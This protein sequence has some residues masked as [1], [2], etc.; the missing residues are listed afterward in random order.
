M[1]KLR[2]GGFQ[3]AEIS[4]DSWAT[5][6]K[7]AE[8]Q[9]QAERQGVRTVSFHCCHHAPAERA[10]V[11]KVGYVEYHK[12][13]YET[14][15]A[16]ANESLTVVEHVPGGPFHKISSEAVERLSALVELSHEYG[17]RIATE[18]MPGNFA[19]P[20]EMES[21]LDRVPGLY[22]TFDAAHAG[23]SSVDPLSFARLFDERLINVHVYD[24]HPRIRLGDWLPIGLGRMDW[25]SILGALHRAGYSGPLTIELTGQMLR[26][27][28]SVCD[29]VLEGMMPQQPPVGSL[30]WEELFAGWARSSLLDIATRLGVEVA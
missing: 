19:L 22:W 6:D 7:W 28:I 21:I 3:H 20:E 2:Q 26:S 14:I 11:L 15:A 30:P 8:V 16:T 27:V 13:L 5:R 24:V 23:Y 12:Q 4:G 9:K 18:N 1:Q 25:S 10:K 17:L 29:A